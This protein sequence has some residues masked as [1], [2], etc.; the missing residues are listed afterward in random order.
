[1]I[2]SL[3]GVV[4]ARY[5]DHVVLEVGGVG[6]RVFVS[7][8]TLSTL[9][10]DSEPTHLHVHTLVRDD[11]INLFGFATE[12]ERATFRAL[13]KVKGVGPKVARTILSVPPSELAQAVEAGNVAW[14]NRLPGVGKRIAERLTME[15]KGR[16]GAA[17]G[18]AAAAVASGAGSQVGVSGEL[19]RALASLGYRPTEV[20]R[21]AKKLKP[22]IDAGDPVDELL[23]Q[24]FK[25]VR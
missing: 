1:M 4:A 7:L 18:S 17:A 13:I 11:L 14:L 12:E 6:Y 25:V 19:G 15:L 21:V 22:R 23:R 5:A 2:A 10:E 24:A 9:P 16:L 8:T 3:R 20:A